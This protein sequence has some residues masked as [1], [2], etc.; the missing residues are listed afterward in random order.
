[1]TT[2]EG[3]GEPSGDVG[4]SLSDTLKRSELASVL[5]GLGEVSVDLINQP[6]LV[7]DIPVLGTLVGLWRTGVTIRDYFFSR[8]LVSFLHAMSSVPPA[9]PREM[10][11]RLEA[12]PA[13]GRNVGEAIVLLLDRLDAVTKA[14]MIGKA[15]KAYCEGSIDSL[16]LQR[17]NYAIDRT[18]LTDLYQLPAFLE[19]PHSVGGTTMQA[20]VNSGLARIPVGTANTEIEAEKRLCSDMVRYVLSS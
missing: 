16:T 5:A 7:R 10:V 9:Q 11:Q 12:D 4:Q 19:R 17:L 1:M 8:K 14:A 6:S 2:P 13:F 18:L 3:R 20:F 15:F